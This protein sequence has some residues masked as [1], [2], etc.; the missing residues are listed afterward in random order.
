[1]DLLWLPYSLATI[2]LVGFGQVFAKETRTQVPSGNI[3]LIFGAHLLVIGGAYFLLAREDGTYDSEV[4]LKAAAAA[5]LS[6]LA[7]VSYFESLKHGKISIVGTIAGAYAPWTVILALVFLG[8][9]M[10]FAEALGVILV[11]GAMLL[12]TYSPNGESGKRT[13]LLGIAFA[14]GSFFLWGTS[15]VVAKGATSDMGSGNFVGVFAA[16]CPSIWAV[17]WLISSKGKLEIPKTDRR[18]FELSMVFLATAVVTLYLAID[19]G[20]VSIVSPV[21]NIYPIVTIA[22]AKYRLKEK[23][24]T[25]QY[26]ALAMLLVSIP[27][28]SL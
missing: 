12:F 17:Y 9:T 4:W 15:A 18:M 5:A 8:E 14:V 16:V 3:V 11:M 7:Y 27:L 22:F 20:N 23:L 25:R 19:N 6:A 26:G 24:T 21:T 1:M 2:L 28:F 10:S 13:E